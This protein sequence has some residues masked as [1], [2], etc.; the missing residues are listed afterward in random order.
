MQWTG[1][2]IAKKNL[3]NFRMFLGTL[4]FHIVFVVV[5]CIYTLVRRIDIF[6]DVKY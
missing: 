5:V 4:C 6:R 2:C 3:R 1:K